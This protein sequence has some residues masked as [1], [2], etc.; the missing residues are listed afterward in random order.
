MNRR[1]CGSCTYCS[2]AA[3]SFA[4][5]ELDSSSSM[6]PDRPRTISASA[7]NATPSPYARH[8][9]ECH[10][11]SA[12]SPSMYFSNSQARRD[13]P[14]PP[15]PTTETRRA[16]LSS[17]VAR[18]LA[19]PCLQIRRTHLGAECRNCVDQVER[20]PYCPLGVVLVRRRR[21]P[22]RHH[23]VADEL[24]DRA[25]VPLDQLAAGLEVAREQLSRVLGVARLGERGEPD[26]VGEENRDEASLGDRRGLR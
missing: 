25:A 12:T 21:P 3:C 22:D 15:T 4:S 19:C 18:Q 6:I 2:M 8:R 16:F 24:L 26:E 13:V 1:S 11:V 20:R 23:C 7:Q 5:A 17:T 9:P 10:S 14:M